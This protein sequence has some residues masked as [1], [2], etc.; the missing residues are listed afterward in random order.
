MSIDYTPIAG[1]G[2][3]VSRNEIIENFN[4]KENENEEETDIIEEFEESKFN[5]KADIKEY[6]SSL[7]GNLGIVL[8]MKEPLKNGIEKVSDK[9]KEF[10]IFLDENGFKN[11]EISFIEEIHQW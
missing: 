6:G 11:K 3:E 10:R 9:L 2:I 1:F 7:S 5:E 4:F 8:L